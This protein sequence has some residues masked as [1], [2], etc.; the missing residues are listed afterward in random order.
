MRFLYKL[1]ELFPNL[2]VSGSS[3]LRLKFII[4]K[5]LLSELNSLKLSLSGINIF[6]LYAWS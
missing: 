4:N 5:Q 6:K 2:N 3:T 1:N